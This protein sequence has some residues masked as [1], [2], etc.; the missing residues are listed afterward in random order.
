MDIASLFTACSIIISQ[1]LL[2][3]IVSTESRGNPYTVNIN[4]DNFGQKS[5]QFENKS[6]AVIFSKDLIQQGYSL[7]LGLGQI[8]SKN[9]KGL[10][11]SVEEVF[12]PCTNLSALQSIFL[13]GYDKEVDQRLTR[14]QK[15]IAALSRYNTGHP[16]R[17]IE[18]GYVYNVLAAKL[19]KINLAPILENFA[20]Q[21]DSNSSDSFN[22]IPDGFTQAAE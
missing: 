17:G 22:S 6:D 2:E 14:E 11:L 12:D 1:P 21:Q 9:L 10:Q 5:Y 15:E 16:T 13:R 19:I 7:D 18:N 4:S 20:S 8:N 3:A